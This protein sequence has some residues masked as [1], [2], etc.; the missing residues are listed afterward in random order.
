MY[1]LSC[2]LPIRRRACAQPP[3]ADSSYPCL[4][5]VTKKSAFRKSARVEAH[6]RRGLKKN[7]QTNALCADSSCPC[8]GSATKEPFLGRIRAW[9]RVHACTSSSSAEEKFSISATAFGILARDRHRCLPNS[10][11]SCLRDATQAMAEVAEKWHAKVSLPAP[12]LCLEACG[13]MPDNG[14][15]SSALLRNHQVPADRRKR[16]MRLQNT[17]A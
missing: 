14:K 12:I 5:R 10:V 15:V 16:H 6:S 4:H 13:R 9:G 17:S 3:C 7:T 11:P 1:T 2:G 8:L